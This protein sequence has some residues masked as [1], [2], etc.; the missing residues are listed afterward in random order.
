[1]NARMAA[2]ACGLAAASAAAQTTINATNHLAYGANIGWLE[3]RGDE[4][5]G[6]VIGQ[7]FCTGYVWSANCGWICLGHGPTNGWRYSNA[8]SNDWGVNHN[9]A[10][11]LGGRAYGANIGWIVF[12][13]TDGR[14]RIDLETGKMDGYAWGANVGWI[15]LSN[16]QAHVQTDRLAAGPDTDGDGIPD[17]WE[18]RMAGD[19]TTLMAGGHDE[20]LDGT[21]DVDEYP[22]DTDPTD[23]TSLLEIVDYVPGAVSNWVAWTVEGSR[24][25]EVVYATNL[26]AEPPAWA[27]SGLGQLAPGGGAV[28]IRGFARPGDT[29]VFYGVKAVVPLAE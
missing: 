6:A 26:V 9:G 29:N 25:Y 11:L 15:S 21:P 19:L 2:L 5:N 12:E 10:G 23:D 17:D 28:M 13:Q 27:D 14:P 16:V 20:D 24:R 18:R 3:I 1:M 8:A 4:T 22:A 7:S